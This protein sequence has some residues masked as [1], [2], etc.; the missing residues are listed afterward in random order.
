MWRSRCTPAA[1]VVRIVSLI[2]LTSCSA[3]EIVRTALS[4]AGCVPI[5]VFRRF[6]RIAVCSVLRICAFC[7]SCVF[8][9]ILMKASVGS[10]E[11]SFRMLRFSCLLSMDM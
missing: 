2:S 4:I 3:S 7:L 8:V 11:I 10:K 5:F 6:S 9:S 1:T